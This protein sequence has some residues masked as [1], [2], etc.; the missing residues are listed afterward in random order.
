MPRDRFPLLPVLL[1]AL[2]GVGSAAEVTHLPRMPSPAFTQRVVSG[3]PLTAQEVRIQLQSAL[4]AGQVLVQDVE[5]PAAQ[6]HAEDSALH[7]GEPHHVSINFGWHPVIDLADDH[8][9]PL[10]HE[11]I[12]VLVDWFEA[13]AAAFQMSP[14]EL[15]VHGYRCNKVARLMRVFTAIRMHRDHGR[16]PG[17]EPAIGWCRIRLQEDWGRCL[18]GESHSFVLVATELGWHVI[19]PFTRRMRKLETNDPRFFVEF[20]VL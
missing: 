11:F 12:P 9:A 4:P 16:D 18:K 15:R 8:Y 20:V 14:E 17:M 6:T 7:R 2:A 13:L 5:P 3:Q 19:D 10:R 1:A